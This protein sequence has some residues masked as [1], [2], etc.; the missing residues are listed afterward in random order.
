RQIKALVCTCSV[1]KVNSMVSSGDWECPKCHSKNVG[2][3]KATK[4]SAKMICNDCGF[5]GSPMKF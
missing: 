4:K 3:A 2:L 1:R 5:K